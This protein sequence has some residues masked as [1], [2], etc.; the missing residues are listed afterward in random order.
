MVLLGL[1]NEDKR[2]SFSVLKALV[3]KATKKKIR[4]FRTNNGGE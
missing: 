3:E 1:H 2:S 4:T